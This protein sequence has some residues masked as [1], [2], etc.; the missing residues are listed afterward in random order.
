[1]H[2]T[3]KQIVSSKFLYLG[4]ALVALVATQQLVTADRSPRL[5]AKQYEQSLTAQ[6]DTDNGSP[7]PGRDPA[8]QQQASLS[9]AASQPTGNGTRT[10]TPAKAII[11]GQAPISPNSVLPDTHKTH[12]LSSGCMVMPNM[13]SGTCMPVN[14]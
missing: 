7:R 14:R 3:L 9:Y 8:S 10:D 12:V 6:V 1:M 13:P 11:G 4:C 2:N 5:T